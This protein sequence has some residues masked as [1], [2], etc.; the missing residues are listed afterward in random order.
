MAQ[1]REGLLHPLLSGS[2]QFVQ[3][4][5][6]GRYG[7]WV[8]GRGGGVCF[9][10]KV[11]DSPLGCGKECRKVELHLFLSL[12][13]ISV[14]VDFIECVLRDGWRSNIYIYFLN[15]YTYNGATCSNILNNK[16][17]T[18]IKTESCPDQC[19]SVHWAL[20]C[21]VKVHQFNSQS[22]H[23]DVSPSLSPSFPSLSK[24]K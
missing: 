22:G 12:F 24:N 6:V 10:G 2:I 23:I 19:G 4:F 14:L 15:K 1:T 16:N 5:Q 8:W 17:C 11:A 13:F 7:F 9:L 20:S 21:D 3:C 18:Q